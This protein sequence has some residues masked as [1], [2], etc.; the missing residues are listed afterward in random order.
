MTYTTKKINVAGTEMRLGFRE[1]VDSIDRLEAELNGRIRRLDMAMDL[2]L[3]R[4]SILA[5]R[6]SVAMGMRE[7]RYAVQWHAMISSGAAGLN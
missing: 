5:L 2:G 3:P 6:R 1:R 4:E 7:Y